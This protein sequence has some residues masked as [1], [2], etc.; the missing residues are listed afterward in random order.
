M[1]R[2]NL[3]T[4]PFYNDRL[5]AAILLLVTA[6]AIAL[7]TYNVRQFMSLSER[8]GSLRAKITQDDVDT[9]LVNAQVDRLLRTVDVAGLKT[10]AGLVKEA[11]LLIDARTFSWTIFFGLIEK[12]LPID[13]RLIA[14][15][16]KVEKGV[17]IVEMT[18]VCRTRDELPTWFKA[19]NDTGAFYD[20]V[21]LAQSQN[22]DGTH[23][24]LVSA[25]YLAP[26]MPAADAQ[27]G[28]KG[29]P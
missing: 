2:G 12:T 17:L 11:N 20:V 26:A 7:T 24:A 21:A 16:P 4:R 22:E 29:H 18:V 23:T 19:L 5:V 3:S 25:T 28:G 1:L 27:A 6:G 10:V 9:S 14:V 13:A 15:A 8:R